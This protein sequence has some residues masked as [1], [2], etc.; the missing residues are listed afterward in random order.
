MP[1]QA[2]RPMEIDAQSVPS[3]CRRGGHTP[4]EFMRMKA[5]FQ[6]MMRLISTGQVTELTFPDCLSSEARKCCHQVAGKQ[7]LYHESVTQGTSR[8]LT[9]RLPAA[10]PMP[11]PSSAPTVSQASAPTVSQA[12]PAT[13]AA[14]AAS[15]HAAAGSVA[16]AA[17]IASEPRERLG[18]NAPCP[19][20]PR[21]CPV[22]G[23]RARSTSMAAYSKMKQC[24]SCICKGT[25]QHVLDHHEG[26]WTVSE[27]RT[28]QIRQQL[29]VHERRQS[30]SAAADTLASVQEASRSEPHEQSLLAS[31]QPGSVHI[32]K[33]KGALTSALAE[34]DELIDKVVKARTEAALSKQ[35]SL[36]QKAELLKS[37]AESSKL[38]ETSKQKEQL[39]QQTRFRLEEQ[40]NK[41]GQKAASKEACAQTSM[42]DAQAATQDAKRARKETASMQRAAALDAKAKEDALA[43]LGNVHNLAQERL[44]VIEALRVQA[45]VAAETSLIDG[46]ARASEVAEKQRLANVVQSQMDASVTQHLTIQAKDDE[47]DALR[48]HLAQ[49]QGQREFEMAAGSADEMGSL[50]GPGPSLCGGGQSVLPVLPANVSSQGVD[51][52]DIAAKVD[53]Q[54]EVQTALVD[55]CDDNEDTGLEEPGEKPKAKRARIQL[56]W[57]EFDHPECA[58]KK[59]EES[60]TK[61]GKLIFKM[62][63]AHCK[64]WRVMR[65]DYDP[66]HFIRH[67]ATCP[68]KLK[69]CAAKNASSLTRFFTTSESILCVNEGRI[70]VSGKPESPA[71]LGQVRAGAASH[72]V[73]HAP[74]IA[75]TVQ[76]CRGVGP[77]NFSLQLSEQLSEQCRLALGAQYDSKCCQLCMSVWFEFENAAA[78]ASQ[79][80]GP[81]KTKGD[82][83]KL[84]KACSCEGATAPQNLSLQKVP[85]DF[86]SMCG[87]RWPCCMQCSALSKVVR[88]ARARNLKLVEASLILHFLRTNDTSHI[89]MLKAVIHSSS[90]STPAWR[91]SA[92][93]EFKEQCK[94]K[95]DYLEF[96][97]DDGFVLGTDLTS[98]WRKFLRSLNY[99]VAV[100]KGNIREKVFTSAFKAFVS[101]IMSIVVSKV[102]LFESQF[103]PRLNRLFNRQ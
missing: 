90:K 96:K 59:I 47:I 78:Q 40:V 83:F 6:D 89:P 102:G 100:N 66:N 17:G 46:Q 60:I 69:A 34:K 50:F 11:S 57:D 9:V 45:A 63:C 81:W 65:N 98:D 103:E 71:I 44:Q 5:W 67:L 73:G 82:D 31:L 55:L 21:G 79:S 22:R 37:Q 19:S 23:C 28:K 2:S 20:V 101:G 24:W 84:I 61:P 42:K 53:Q 26:K 99:C 13:E 91:Q 97:R 12:L 95:R 77:W 32:A 51:A 7:K 30:S 48:A 75:D 39:H 52:D 86:Q 76:I 43:E 1:Q 35:T 38:R 58:G 92:F 3:L 56:R 94:I 36:Q 41:S 33:Y 85:S 15:H 68:A 80:R 49:L 87:G 29:S 4:A 54:D 18:A 10:A 8:H 25:P 88:Q 72:Q 70:P 14:G 62:Q 74:L 16:A 64:E 27:A 93:D